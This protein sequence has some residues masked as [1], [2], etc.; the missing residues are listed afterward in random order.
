MFNYCIH[1]FYIYVKSSAL[2]LD[3]KSLVL[4][5]VALALGA[6]A[7]TPSLELGEIMGAWSKP[8]KRRFEMPVKVHQIT[9]RH[10]KINFELQN[11]KKMC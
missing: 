8:W 2:A 6:L 11:N 3:I 1:I 9:L 7:L 4:I 5:P 10:C